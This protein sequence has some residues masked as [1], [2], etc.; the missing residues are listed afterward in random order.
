MVGLVDMMPTLLDLVGLPVPRD[1]QGQSFAPAVRNPASPPA[2]RLMFAQIVQDGFSLE[3]I[4]DGRYKD[5]RH[6]H[7][8]RQGQL[9]LYDL[10]E[11][12]LERANLAGTMRARVAELGAALDAFNRVVQQKASQ[13]PSERVKTLDRDT[14]R[15]LRSLG[16]IK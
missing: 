10:E 9:E 2:T 7:G 14:E 8:P 6:I 13:I 15:A 16:Y 12:P 5:I 11:D 1:I 4:R 3:M